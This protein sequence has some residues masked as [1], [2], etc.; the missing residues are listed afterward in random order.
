MDKRKLNELTR[1]EL[2]LLFDT[3]SYLQGCV[4]DYRADDVNY[5]VCNEIISYFETYDGITNRRKIS[6]LFDEDAYNRVTIR[7]Q[8]VTAF[9]RDLHN[10]NT[11]G[12]GLS[13]KGREISERLL[14]RV[15][16][17][18]D[19][20]TGYSEMS[21]ARWDKF[22]TWFTNGIAQIKAELSAMLTNEY[23]SIYDDETNKEYF[24][25][26]VYEL[27]YFSDMT[28]DGRNVYFEV[29]KS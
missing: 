25:D 2:E 15:G 29:C 20:V 11:N 21:D 24:C 23:N 7:I 4:I 8:D 3:N 18:E 5:F 1:E 19:N 6:A 22:E 9:L 10:F 27:G 26:G 28:T 12:Y 14:K 13:D 16:V 17:Y